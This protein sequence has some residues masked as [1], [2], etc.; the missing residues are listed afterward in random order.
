M[1]IV[2]RRGKQFHRLLSS[3]DDVPE[4]SS[5]AATMAA[6][7]RRRCLPLIVIPVWSAARTWPRATGDIRRLR[8]GQAG[9]DPTIMARIERT[10]SKTL[11]GSS[12]GSF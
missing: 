5:A 4:R 7:S 11:G 12:A 8:R 10:G 2:E 1:E 3:E 6:V 9:G